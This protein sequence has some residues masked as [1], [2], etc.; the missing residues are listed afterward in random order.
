[1]AGREAAGNAEVNT[2]PADVEQAI[3]AILR[4]MPLD[5]RFYQVHLDQHNQPETTS[6]KQA[7]QVNVLITILIGNHIEQ[8]EADVT[9]GRNDNMS[10]SRS[11]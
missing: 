1:L 10:S 5:T 2:N 6:L 4:R 11:L 9:S 7:S 8:R 3:L